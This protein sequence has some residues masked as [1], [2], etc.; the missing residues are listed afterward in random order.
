[1]RKLTAAIF[2]P[3]IFTFSVV[4][5]NI[6]RADALADFSGGLGDSSPNQFP[7]F[8]GQG[9]SDG[10]Q[11]FFS[12]RLE[13]AFSFEIEK[14]SSFEGGVD[15]LRVT[16]NEDDGGFV[17]LSRILDSSETVLKAPQEVS[18]QIRVDEFTGSENE[19]FRFS[20]SG[21]NQ[22]NAK[23]PGPGT[24]CWFLFAE[25]NQTW[26]IHHRGP[27]GE[28]AL[29]NT[30][31]PVELGRIYSIKVHLQPAENTFSITLKSDSQ[32]H[33]SPTLSSMDISGVADMLAFGGWTHNNGPGK[34]RW[35]LGP[36][37]V[38]N[39]SAN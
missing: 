30:K 7:G 22:E 32:F 21:I 12:H 25:L 9:W 38:R 36:V 15:V 14:D 34:F 24:S 13:E 17:R 29:L 3:L 31:I 1:M 26:A 5:A 10:W 39:P 37:S 2:W 28:L 16:R 33:E 4:H 19:P 27:D 20:L 8:S 6:S 35:S 11:K 23:T 18:F